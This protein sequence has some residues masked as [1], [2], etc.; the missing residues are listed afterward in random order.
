MHRHCGRWITNQRPG[1]DRI[2][3]M[4]SKVWMQVQRT[5]L[6]GVLLLGALACS[7]PSLSSR[8][9]EGRGDIVVEIDAQALANFDGRWRTAAD[10]PTPP[11]AE[12]LQ[13]VAGKARLDIYLG[14]WC[15]DS[16]REVGRFL[17]VLNQAKELPFAV[18][19]YTLPSDKSVW[20]R[21]DRDLRY[22]PTFIVRQGPK[23]VGR[24]VESAPRGIEVELQALL[25]GERAG[26]VS[27]R[28]DL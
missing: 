24:I 20:P 19:F 28:T 4:P 25:S 12:A 3:M 7:G 10:G 26:V 13:E 9:T 14:T 22:V 15:P 11:G 1:A 6:A 2:L 18:S 16:L 21:D 5:F 17:R 23:E 27:G 8:G